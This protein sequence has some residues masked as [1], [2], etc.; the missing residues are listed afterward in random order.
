MGAGTSRA[1]RLFQHDMGLKVDG[2]PSKELLAF[3]T[4]L[5]GNE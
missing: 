1:I 3:M 2:R 5:A 4:K